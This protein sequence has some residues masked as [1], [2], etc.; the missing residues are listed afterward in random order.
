MQPA[1]GG[2]HAYLASHLEAALLPCTPEAIDRLVG[3]D[4][5]WTDPAAAMDSS[6]S[7]GASREA[8]ELRL[9]TD[10]LVALLTSESPRLIAATSHDQWRRACLHGRTAA[11]L[12]RYHAKMA[13]TSGS[14]PKT[15]GF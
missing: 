9:L 5:R 15:P 11:G 2:L 14:R 8:G 7:V 10:D 1:P 12:L 6:R 4:G 3:D 13:D